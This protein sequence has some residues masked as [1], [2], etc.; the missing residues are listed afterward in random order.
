MKTLLAKAYC[1]L[2]AVMCTC[3]VRGHAEEFSISIGDTVSDG[4]PVAGAGRLAVATEEDF[5]TFQAETG[6]LA[7]FESLSQD[8]AFQRALRWQLARPSGGT[9][10]ASLFSN[11]QGRTLLTE[12]GVYRLRIYSDARDPSWVGPYSFR[13]LS[14]PPDQT[15]PF[16]IGNVVSNG[17]PA[18]GAGRL[19]VAGSEDN[20][21]FDA[22]AGQVVFFQ[23]I[24]QDPAF[25]SALRWQL[26]RP[27][28]GSAFASLFSNPQGR[29]LLPE[30]GTYRIRIHTDGTT[31]EWFGDYAFKVSPIPPDETFEYT[32]GTEVADGIPKS[33]AGRIETAGAED[34]YLFSGT[35]GQVIFFQSNNQEPAFQFGLRWQLLKPSGGA[36]FSSLFSNPQG[37]I[38]LPDTGEYRI[39]IFTD[40]TNP[41]WFGAYSFSTRADVSDQQFEINVGD[42]V[43]EGMPVAGAGSL[44]TPGSTDTYSFQGRAGQFLIFESLAQAPAFQGNLRWELTT[45]SGTSLFASLFANPQGRVQLSVAGVYKIRIL[46]GSDNP[47]WIG[48]YSFRTYSPVHAL[49]D[50]IATRPNEPIEVGLASLL[51]N[52]GAED[53]MDVLSIEL[54]DPATVEG[55]IVSRVAE[56]VRYVPSTD[57][58]GIDRFTYL[59]K[60]SLGGTNA[61]T[62]LVAVMPDVGDFATVVSVVRS[63]L[64]GGDACL[65][66]EPSGEYAVETSV[67]FD[68]WTEAST[69]SADE[70]GAMKLH[71]EVTPPGTNHLFLRGRRKE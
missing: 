41:D 37:R 51:C 32:I 71:F 27:S 47:A 54:T 11:P 43:S 12:T 46:T 45:P 13:V 58:V 30:T 29:V 10:F 36:V 21:T 3:V 66:G 62:V 25:K 69:L 55:G 42:I 18:E 50:T 20:Y 4:V 57:F 63:G 59:L 40:S 35:A 61:A 16:I 70:E 8:A 2:I 38:V 48:A 9:A 53:A 60:G 22:T 15:F 44:E 19:E 67:D 34:N 64:A 49:S 24:R 39:R 14:I 28:G 5:Y 1:V 31:A 52:D 65:L 6:Q 56:K 17:V 26:V 23:S 68:T 7:F 33:G